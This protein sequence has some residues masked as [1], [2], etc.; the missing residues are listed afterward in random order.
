MTWTFEVSKTPKVFDYLRGFKNLEG[1]SL[2]LDFFKK[3]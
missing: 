1:F 2:T 3:L